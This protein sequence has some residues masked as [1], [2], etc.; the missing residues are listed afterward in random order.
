MPYTS[1]PGRQVTPP[2][3]E[4]PQGGWPAAIFYPFLYPVP[5]TCADLRIPSR[6][7]PPKNMGDFKTVSLPMSLAEDVKVEHLRSPT[8][9]LM[10][11]ATPPEAAHGVTGKCRDQV[12]RLEIL[13]TSGFANIM[14]SR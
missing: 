13:I 1:M 10:A 6:S 3:V 2:G 14:N 11:T 7:S 8:S 4:R 9:W 5:L 12:D